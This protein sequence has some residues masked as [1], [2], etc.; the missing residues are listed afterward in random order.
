MPELL[1]RMVMYCV[2]IYE[3]LENIEGKMHCSRVL[4]LSLHA[5]L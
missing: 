2:S 1:L 4:A 3:F 5:Y